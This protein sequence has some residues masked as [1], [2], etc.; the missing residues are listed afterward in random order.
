MWSGKKQA[1]A[2][3]LNVSMG[4]GASGGLQAFFTEKYARL[5]SFWLMGEAEVKQVFEGADRD[6]I[7]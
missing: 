4:K 7:L 1:F 2:D 6:F 5:C 3:R